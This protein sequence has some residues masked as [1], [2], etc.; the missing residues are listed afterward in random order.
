MNI[1]TH[2]WDGS[3][4]QT[5]SARKTYDSYKTHD[6]DSGTGVAYVDV[7][8]FTYY[9]PVAVKAVAADMNGDGRDEIVVQKM[10]LDF[11]FHY[12]YNYNEYSDPVESYMNYMVYYCVRNCI[13]VWNFDRGSI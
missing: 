10:V 9:L 11:R 3:T 12:Q 7:I 13:D 6:Y 2:K 5:V 4:F 8:E 1:V